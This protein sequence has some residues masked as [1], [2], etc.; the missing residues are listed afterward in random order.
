MFIRTYTRTLFD[1]IFKN[2]FLIKVFSKIVNFYVKLWFK[3]QN[4]VKFSTNM[5]IDDLKEKKQLFFQSVTGDKID[6]K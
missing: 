2:K 6:C 4:S 5:S 3:D 1:N